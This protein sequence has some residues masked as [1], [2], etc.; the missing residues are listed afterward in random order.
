MGVSSTSET[1]MIDLLSE[2]A[3]ID[4][5]PLYHRFRN[6]APVCWYEPFRSWLVTRYDDSVE[7]LRS[8]RF[9]AA[10]VSTVLTNVLPSA[11]PRVV[12]SF[13]EVVGASLFFKDPPA[14]TRMREVMMRAAFVPTVLRV[15]EPEI[16]RAV[17]ALV[18]Q[19]LETG[20]FDAVRDFAD[21]LPVL[22][23]A[24]LVGAPRRDR[25]TLRQWTLEAISLF[26]GAKLGEGQLRRGQEAMS[27]LLD[28][29]HRLALRSPKVGFIGRLTSAVELGRLAPEESCALLL[30]LVAGG[31]VPMSNLLGKGFLTLLAHPEQVSLL[32]EHPALWPSAVEELLR[33]DTPNQLTSRIAREEIEIR[34]QLIHKDE[35]I[36]IMLGA[37][38][39]DPEMFPNP[40]HFDIRRSPN[41]HLAF[42]A[43]PHYC[44]G[45]S[46]ARLEARIAFRTVFQRMPNLRLSARPVVWR[47]GTLRSSGPISVPLDCR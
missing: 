12:R 11:D 6:E 3:L 8:A 5:Y 4:P 19:A 40:D 44:A 38:N 21:E 36:Y 15:L 18:D 29:V 47:R 45:A 33:F 22:I 43:G 37:A 9:S 34:G 26:G 27:A 35:T 46:L 2:N 41:R 30:D 39:R 16:Q 14:H 28:Y 24:K 23:M 25:Q 10:R 42:G 7:V 1:T 13:S 20:G 32:H 17:D 31:H